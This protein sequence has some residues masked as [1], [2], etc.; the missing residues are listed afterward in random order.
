ML[1]IHFPIAATDIQ[2][3]HHKAKIAYTSF[4]TYG[5]SITAIVVIVEVISYF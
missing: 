3:T 5:V 1:A 4:S 2:P